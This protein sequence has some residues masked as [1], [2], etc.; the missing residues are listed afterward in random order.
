MS[1]SRLAKRNRD[2]V[3]GRIC[4]IGQMRLLSLLLLLCGAWGGCSA[5]PP[6]IQHATV[7]MGEA[8]KLAFAQYDLDN[9]GAISKD[10]AVTFPVVQRRFS[11]FDQNRDGNVTA[12]EFKQRLV[13]IY[14]THVALLSATCIVT[15]KGRPLTGAVV[16]FVPEEFLA[17][18]IP[19]AEGVVDRNGNAI[20]SIKIE[21]LP[22]G[23]PR[24]EGF[25]RPGLYRVV[26]THPNREIPE[27]YN[28]ETILGEDVS[29]ETVIGGP[30]RFEL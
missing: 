17:G 8:S 1:C 21:D 16:R 2:K 12:E 10:E 23:A 13:T 15:Q 27:K 7:D 26:I 24:V 11:L 5:R 18:A 25:I 4:Y 6:R 14:G 20:L 30:F 29:A 28:R 3:D 22:A 19:I 9:N